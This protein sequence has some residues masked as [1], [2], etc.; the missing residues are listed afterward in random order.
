ML[1]RRKETIKKLHL[2][3]LETV[4]YVYDLVRERKYQEEGA[5]ECHTKSR[6][7]TSVLLGDKIVCAGFVNLFNTIL[8]KL[9][10]KCLSF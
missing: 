10:I 1:F 7:L 9:D 5:N 2:S 3:P 8:E 4:L 6:D